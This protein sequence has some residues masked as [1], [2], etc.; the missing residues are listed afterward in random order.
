MQ[1][2]F[3]DPTT[4]SITD[5][6]RKYVQSQ[7]EKVEANGLLLCVT[8]SGC[9]GYMFELGYVRNEPEDV[10][11]F[12]FDGNVRV[13]VENKHWDL[14]RG[15]NIDYVTEGLNSSLKFNNPNAETLCGCGESFS[16]RGT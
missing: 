12:N 16:V 5:T 4:I 10:K 15:T 14:V 9:N 7:L 6:A 1:A 11:T 8:A 3:F 13:Y 2:D